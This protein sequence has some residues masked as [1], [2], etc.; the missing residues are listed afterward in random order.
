L[1]QASV[2]LPYLFDRGTNKEV[3]IEYLRTT[4]SLMQAEAQIEKIFADPNIADKESSSAYVRAQ[5]DK[6]IARQNALA[7]LAEATLQSQIGEAAAELG[8]TTS[9]QP[10]HRFSSHLSTFALIVSGSVI[11]Q[12]QTSPSC[13][14]DPDDQIKLRIRWRH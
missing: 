8:L 4:Q 2:G 14:T 7:P 10:I 11:E 6:L 12:L 13:H 9:G 5:R 3:V 1:Q